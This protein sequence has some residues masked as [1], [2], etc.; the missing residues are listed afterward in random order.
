MTGREIRQ[1]T[2]PLVLGWTPNQQG[3]YA[4]GW[5]DEVRVW[6]RARSSVEVRAD[7][8]CKLTGHEPSLAG[9]WNFDDLT[10]NDQT[11]NGNHGSFQ[12]HAASVLR[13]T[14]DMGLVGC[15]PVRFLAGQINAPNVDW[16][17]R[18]RI[19]ADYLILTST[20]LSNW[21]P[22]GVVLENNGFLNLRVRTEHDRRFFRAIIQP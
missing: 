9:Y 14:A 2:Q 5:I 18:G 19:G 20:N 22:Y 6:S 8:A 13:T 10:G 15:D 3:T 7:M 12:G 21:E 16:G 11:V 17:L 1:T 4:A